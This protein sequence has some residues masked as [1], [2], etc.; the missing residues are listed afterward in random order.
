VAGAG[1]YKLYLSRD[2]E[3]T[4]LV[5]G[6]PRYV[7]NTIWMSFAALF[8]SQAGEAFYWSVSPCVNDDICNAPIHAPWAFNKKS[9]PVELT[10]PL[11]NAVVADDVTFTWSDY[12]DTNQSPGNLDGTG[13][14]PRIEAQKYRVEVS[15]DPNFQTTLEK[16]D[17]DQTTYTSFAK[18]YP[19]G[20]L[21]WR[22]SAVDGSD[23]VLTSSEVRSF[24]K[25]SDAPTLTSPTDGEVVS[26]TEAFRWEAMPFTSSYEIEV[27][28]DNDTLGQ[29]ANKVF[30]GSSKQA[31]FTT[32]TPLP[33]SDLAYT[34]RVRRVDASGNDGAWTDLA[35]PSAR[36][37]ISGTAPSLTAPAS[38][39]KLAGDD[40]L[41][42][43]LP[44]PGA[45]AYRF[46]R[47][48]AGSASMAEVV[49]TPALA[50]APVKI[51]DQG[52]WQWRVS[53]LDAAGKVSATSEW[54]SFAV[55]GGRPTVTAKSPT[56]TVGGSTS[57]AARFS[58]RVTKVS[59]TTF[60]VY[61][62]GLPDPLPA[63]VSL[64]SSGTKATL[65]PRSNLKPGKTY[66]VKLTSGITDA[67]GNGLVATSWKVSVR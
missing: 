35:A 45:S 61:Q 41:F 66:T 49:T 60:R 5:K 67:A 42:T 23:N 57:F 7:D 19:E 8:D 52:S 50:W 39:A 26:Q 9:N 36:F 28:K 29:P 62:K 15:D 20:T 40:A 32:T 21:Y 53:S 48:A 51:I 34:W 18:A 25:E 2:K 46:E 30:S 63:K 31:A 4:N 58:E 24:V 22:V 38:S 14:A 27:Y 37:K 54:R 11:N 59:S 6:Y 47:R 64:D 33:A 3:M 44:V 1:G 17:V 10:A 56:G 12:L 13:V 16:V 43:W 55:D 65:V